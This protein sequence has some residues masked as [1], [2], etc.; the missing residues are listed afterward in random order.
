MAAVAGTV[1]QCWTLTDGSV[2]A[3]V[4]VPEAI[5]NVQYHVTIPNAKALTAAQLQAAV[6][7]AVAG[8]RA[9]K[10]ALAVDQ[11]ATLVGKVLSV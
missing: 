1:N 2:H 4:T 3:V 10:A 6:Q 11:A 8:Q 9:G 7:A 5:G